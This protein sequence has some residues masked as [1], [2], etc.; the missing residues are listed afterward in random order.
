MTTLV[1]SRAVLKGAFPKKI[2]VLSYG[3]N[4]Y[5]SDKNRASIHAEHDAIN[6]LPFSRKKRDINMLIIRFTNDTQQ[7]MTMSKP[8]DKCVNMMISVFPKKGYCIR[9][10]YYSDYDGSIVKTTLNR[11]N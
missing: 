7:K 6:K 10:I 4:H 5:C 2:N 9:N 8:C 11:L 1:I 3:Q